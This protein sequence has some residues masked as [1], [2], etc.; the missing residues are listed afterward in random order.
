MV[1]VAQ[2]AELQIV[3]LA[4]AGSN[5]VTHPFFLTSA[6]ENLDLLVLHTHSGGKSVLFPDFDWKQVLM[7]GLIGGVI[8]VTSAWAAI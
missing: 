5:P 4:V 6:H 1:G 8:G 7:K 2:L 3:V